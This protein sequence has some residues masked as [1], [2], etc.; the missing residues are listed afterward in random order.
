MYSPTLFN[1][2]YHCSVLV[3]VIADV[4]FVQGGARPIGLV[5]WLDSPTAIPKLSS[6]LPTTPPSTDAPPCKAGNLTFVDIAPSALTGDHGL[7]AQPRN[8]GSACLLSRTPKV[9]AKGAGLPNVSATKRPMP[10]FG[11]AADTAP[12]KAVYLF[13]EASAA[14][15]RPGQGLII[16]STLKIYFTLGGKLVIKDLKLSTYCGVAI[17]PFCS[18]KRPPKYLNPQ[19]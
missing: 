6:P 5:P 9:V 10:F 4:G 19:H 14:C 3:Q 18:V 2:V 7:N 15:A 1:H 8:S 12:G 11:Q 16:Y 17:S 13:A